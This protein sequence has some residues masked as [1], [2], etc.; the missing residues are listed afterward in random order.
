MVLCLRFSRLLVVAL[1]C[2][3]FCFGQFAFSKKNCEGPGAKAKLVLR[4]P[5]FG[6][7]TRPLQ[8]K[9]VGL[10]PQ[11]QQTAACSHDSLASCAL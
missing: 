5:G 4:R 7:V 3:E 8:K 2:L 10:H 9:K 11:T 6:V 1:L